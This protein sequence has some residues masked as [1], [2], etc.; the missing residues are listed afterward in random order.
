MRDVQVFITPTTLPAIGRL[1]SRCPFENMNLGFTMYSHALDQVPHSPRT[2]KLI[3][4]PGHADD[5]PTMNGATNT[6][7]IDCSSTN[8]ARQALARTMKAG[9]QCTTTFMIEYNTR[10]QRVYDH[11]LRQQTGMITDE[12]QVYNEQWHRNVEC[13]K[14]M[15][16]QRH[17]R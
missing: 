11:S 5:K 16:L 6:R 13:Q 3:H 4:P 15:R 9:N 17:D 8:D 1:G 7:F 10:P 12:R 14:V 2:Q